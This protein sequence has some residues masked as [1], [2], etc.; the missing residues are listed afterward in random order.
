M[1]TR[2]LPISITANPGMRTTLHAS[3]P[4][5]VVARDR[6]PRK[7][8][9]TLGLALLVFGSVATMACDDDPPSPPPPC[10]VRPIIDNFDVH[11]DTISHGANATI[12]YVHYELRGDGS[13]CDPAF[14][15]LT[16][17]LGADY[18]GLDDHSDFMWISVI[19]DVFNTLPKM[20][21]FRPASSPTAPYYYSWSEWSS[22]TALG[23]TIR[24]DGETVVYRKTSFPASLHNTRTRVYLVRTNPQFTE[25]ADNFCVLAGLD[26]TVAKIGTSTDFGNVAVI[27][28]PQ[29]N[30][31]DTAIANGVSAGQPWADYGL[32]PACAPL[33]G[34]SLPWD[35]KWWV[36]HTALYSLA[37]CAVTA[38]SDLNGDG[39]PDVAYGAPY[40]YRVGAANA[41]MVVVRS[42]PNGTVVRTHAGATNLDAF[43]T[44]VALVGDIDGDGR[45]DLAVGAPQCSASLDAGDAGYVDV[46][47][48]ATGVQRHHWVG[49]A[50]GDL[51][52]YRVLG[53]GDLNGDGTGDVLVGAPGGGYIVV[54]SGATGAVLMQVIGP[55]ANSSFGWS[56]AWGD[57]T[58]D[59]VAEIVVGS[60]GDLAALGGGVGRVF[61]IDTT[62]S[63]IAQ[64]Y[65]GPTGFGFSVAVVG[66][67]LV[68]GSPLDNNRIGR[69]V[70]YSP[71]GGSVTSA[72]TRIKD[73]YGTALCAGDCDGDG[74]DEVI[75]G[76]PQVG[77]GGTPSGRGYV[78]AR[79]IGSL[80]LVG[81]AVGN[82][83]R[84]AFGASVATVGDIDSDG[85]KEF[86]IG[87]PYAHQGGK[88]AGSV[89]VH[90]LNTAAPIGAFHAQYGVGCYG[91]QATGSLFQL[92]PNTALASAALP[93]NAMQMT[94]TA[95]G[96]VATWLA[97][98]ATSVYVPPSGGA[99]ALAPTDDG[100]DAVAPT[101]PIPSPFGAAVQLT[102]SHNGIVTLG[103]VG[104]N[105]GDFTPRGT[106]LA[107]SAGA[108]FYVWYDYDDT[109]VGSGRIKVEEV[110]GVMYLTWDGV[111]GVGVLTAPNPHTFQIQ[112]NE[113]TGVVTYVWIAVSA[114]S[115]GGR[116]YL[117]G[118]TDAGVSQN[119]GSIDLATALPVVTRPDYGGAPLTLSASPAPVYSVGNPSV[120][121]TY[122]VSNIIDVAP[123]LGIG[124]TVLV[125]SLASFPGGLDLGILGMP[126]CDLNIASLDVVLPLAGG[127]APVDTIV[128]TIPQPLAPGLSFYSQAVSLFAPNSLPNGQNA[129]GG[130]LSNGLRSTFNTF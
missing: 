64:T 92:W 8:P 79:S 82:Y 58:G 76:A 98:A 4:T 21:D 117:V 54:R 41:G 84:E 28:S 129:L 110:G 1:T 9:R 81:R 60:P 45:S 48:G 102:V 38:G 14:V 126:A 127:G 52:G 68:V 121:I 107:Q 94:P 42:G 51:F 17:S 103:S 49:A 114:A 106:D 115:A 85:I 56:L 31:I 113:V 67:R 29:F 50:L 66:G 37:G 13:N 87:S 25:F 88:F 86:V 6:A 55:T 105:S 7:L 3:R 61:V 97:G 109:E 72:G 26:Y 36:N 20:I 11:A 71:T 112:I 18:A 128:L 15:Q 19:D 83:A 78:E 57:V 93:G 120:P 35:P 80:A 63:A 12:G 69:V 23:K 104:N 10:Q 116:E 34:I 108:A 59:G 43:G 95:D 125:F 77:F 40:D 44:S 101:V 74:T 123:P 53:I 90:N 122:T 5:D 130:L 39:V 47:S 33:P 75:V 111:E 62:T 73:Y 70:A 124:V 22:K 89:S 27:F 91:S 2:K 119:P 96:Y 65:Q 24:T 32:D 30:D 46:Y 16:F 118:Y 99:T 100:D